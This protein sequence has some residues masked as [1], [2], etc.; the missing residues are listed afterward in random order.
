M[1]LEITSTA[2]FKRLQ[3]GQ[4]LFFVGMLVLTPYAA[5]FKQ[6]LVLMEE[7]YQSWAQQFEQAHPGEWQCFYQIKP[8]TDLAQAQMT[9]TFVA[10]NERQQLDYQVFLESVA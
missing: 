9:L 2:Y 3:F 10:E 1:Q 5:D 7:D 8:N 4:V 6:Q